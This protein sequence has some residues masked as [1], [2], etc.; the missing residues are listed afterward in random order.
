MPIFVKLLLFLFFIPLTAYSQDCPPG[1]VKKKENGHWKCVA[2]TMQPLPVTLTYFKGI[3]EDTL[4]RLYWSTATESNNSHF[5]IEGSTNGITFS[6][7]T[8]IQ[9]KVTTTNTTQYYN[10]LVRVYSYYR[11]IQVDMDGSK[12]TYPIIFVQYS[13][14]N[15]IKLSIDTIGRTIK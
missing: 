5:I 15:K 14:L 3:Q 4:I 12:I 6:Q 10:T 2:D 13:E 7:L 9:S 8:S 1:F 11:L